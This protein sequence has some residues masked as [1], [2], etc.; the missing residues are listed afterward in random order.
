M[1]TQ[2][3]LLAA[4]AVVASVVLVLRHRPLLFPVVAIVVSGVEVLS[5]FGLVHVSIAKV[6]LGLL[7]GAAL[8]VAGIGVY[9]RSADK[10]TVAAATT[11]ALVGALQ[12][13]ASIH[14]HS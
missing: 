1:L 7:F 3:M 12:T 6:P 13:L 2:P 8:V 10:S 4:L 14:L 5:A 9:V 11:I